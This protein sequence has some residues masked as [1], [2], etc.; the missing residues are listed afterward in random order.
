MKKMYIE[1]DG[2]TLDLPQSFSFDVEDSS[3][4]FNDRGSMSV[5]A[6]VPPTPG[7]MRLMGF[8][9]RLDSAGS[10]CEKQCRVVSGSFIRS[11][12]LNVTSVSQR[13]GVS[14]NIG[15]GNSIAYEKWQKKQ[16]N[17][18]AN[19]PVMVFEADDDPG[20]DVLDYMYGVVYRQ[21][22]PAEN[23][24]AVFPIAVGCESVKNNGASGTSTDYW[25]ILNAPGRLS[26]EVSGPVI[27][28][29]GEAVTELTVPHRYGI[30]PFLRVWYVLDLIF[31]DLGLSIASNPFKSGDLARLVI[32]NNTAD[33]LCT[34]KVHVADLMPDNSVESFLNALWVRFG[35]VYNINWDTGAADI[36]LLRDILGSEASAD[37]SDLAASM[38]GI[39]FAA[40]QYLSLSAST[41]F[42]G[43]APANDRF[44]DFIKGCDTDG[45]YVTSTPKGNEGYDCLYDPVGSMWYKCDGKGGFLQ[46]SSAFFNWNPQSAGMEALELSSDDECVPMKNVWGESDGVH[47]PTPFYQAGSRHMHT[48]VKGSD[49]N[50][51]DTTGCPLAF[52][53]AFTGTTD[54]PLGTIGR[55]SHETGEGEV[56]EW[57]GGDVSHSTTLIFQFKNGL[58]DKFWRAYDSLIRNGARTCRVN[59]AFP[60]HSL[61]SLDPFSPVRFSGG[62]CL[63]DKLKYSLPAGAEVV[64]DASMRVVSCRC[65]DKEMPLI[66]SFC[67][68]QRGWK[69]IS[70]NMNSIFRLDRAR[71]DAVRLYL[72]PNSFHPDPQYETATEKA[73]L[74]AYPLKVWAEGM[75]WFTDPRFAVPPPAESRGETVEAEYLCRASYR[76]V[77]EVRYKRTGESAPN[78][79]A[80]QITIADAF[81]IPLSYTVILEKI[82]L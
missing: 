36:R 16:L 34:G 44:E 47:G 3:P 64:A 77:L 63:I 66:P 78:R 30:T 54:M 80:K 21:A 43:A 82:G 50:K 19:L 33:A 27:R 68:L 74:V 28:V 9:G 67:D 38:P 73:V 37:W 52:M 23:P 22:D 45:V 48:Y 24:F 7:N 26:G 39:D 72:P 57:P 75:T 13:G 14:F 79:P 76:M 69:M 41:S 1:I 8:A 12:K 5:P 2:E 58:Y 35:C 10:V 6:T 55:L 31:N 65:A 70:N 81:E 11:G 18:L 40:R 60:L 20:A 62:V 15:F 51:A 71:R 32:L 17:E 53:W 59:L 29:I 49:D 4:V 56:L 61:L 46:T 25:E 42:E